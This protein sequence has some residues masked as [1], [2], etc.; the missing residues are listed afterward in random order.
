MSLNSLTSHRVT[1]ELELEAT[2]SRPGIRGPS[3]DSIGSSKPDVDNA[4]SA[5]VE[6]VPAET[7]TMY[8]AVIAAM[9]ELAKA[10][11][12]ARIDATRVYWL[13]TLLTPI[14]YALIYGGKRRAAGKPRW[15]SR[16]AWPWWQMIAATIAFMA[17]GLTVT[18]G[19][20]VTQGSGGA[21]AGLLAI[22]V[23]T[24]LGVG[25]RFFAPV[26]K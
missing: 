13:F 8:L 2:P 4:L 5:L 24:L 3:E 16:S 26:K 15:P 10:L 25:G 22:V 6:Y 19:P 17:W 21:V 12:G 20:F 1:R 11:P 18:G 23:S 14:L 7:I 9:P